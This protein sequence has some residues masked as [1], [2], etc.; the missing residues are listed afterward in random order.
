M[1]EPNL[2]GA[3]L[4]SATR[5]T[6]LG[7]PPRVY[8]LSLE[9][10]TLGS[11]WRQPPQSSPG[12]TGEIGVRQPLPGG[13]GAQFLSVPSPHPPVRLPGQPGITSASTLHA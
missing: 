12:L 5:G 11:L 7:G 1:S 2:R 8:K 9:R 10:Q 6:G 3:Q 13:G 4:L